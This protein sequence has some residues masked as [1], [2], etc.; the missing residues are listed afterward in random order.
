MTHRVRPPRRDHI[1]WSISQVRSYARRVPE[2]LTPERA[3][4]LFAE[5][6]PARGSVRA[7]SRF[8]EGSV[9]GA[10]RVD[11][12][13]DV[14]SAPVVLKIYEADGTWWAAK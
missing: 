12:A 1:P 7:V 13:D 2:E 8:A 3:G 6:L 5:I 4:E 14:D 11:F 9:T 10:Y